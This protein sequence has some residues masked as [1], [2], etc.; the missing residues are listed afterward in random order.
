M[1]AISVSGDLVHY[2]KLGRGKPVVLIHGWIGSWR[3]W[4]PL[5]RQ[6]QLKY[7]VYALDLFGYGDSGKNP[8][9]YPIG[10]QVDMLDTFMDELFISKAAFIGHGLGAMV[11]TAF[12]HRHPEKVARLLIASAP[13]F[14]PGEL[15]SRIPPDQQRQ[16]H[17]TDPNTLKDV[18]TNEPVSTPAVTKADSAQS[19]AST[20]VAD[21]SSHEDPT[22]VRRPAGLDF[23][24]GRAGSPPD[25]TVS[26]AN[27]D[28]VVN[29]SSFIDREKLRQA[30][31]ARGQQAMGDT[32]DVAPDSTNPI[33][34]ADNRQQKFHNP[35]KD[36]MAQSSD[37]LLQKCFKQSEADY[38][39]LENVV[40]KMDDRVMQV[41]AINFDSGIMLD[42]FRQ[43]QSPLVLI[44]GEDDPVIPSPVEDVW[45]YLTADNDQNLLPISLPGVRH[46][47]MLEFEPFTRLVG[48]F[49]ETPN[50]N[51]IEIRERWRRRTR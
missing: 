5:M 1:S 31:L 29:P 50:I 32:S 26:S 6:L 9:R 14:D 40:A 51:D 48:Q 16:L 19:N 49:L 47:P 10:Q 28:T 2:E 8:Q 45:N 13:L 7:A 41:S 21:A 33:A 17:V 36:I 37:V 3:Y 4:I 15:D 12:A 24:L 44:H 39:K 38:D 34:Q 23:A 25:P 18:P 22:L 42:S 20:E 11:A 35:L 30:A 46:F 43:L 27:N